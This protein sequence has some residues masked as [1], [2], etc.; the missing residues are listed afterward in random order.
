MD[1]SARGFVSVAVSSVASS[2]DAEAGACGLRADGSV[3]CWGDKYAGL[4]PEGE[5]SALSTGETPTCGVRVEGSIEC[6]GTDRG[7]SLRSWPGRFAAVGAAGTEVC[8]IHVGGRLECWDVNGEVW[9]EPNGEFGMVKAL[10]RREACGLRTDGTI[11]CTERLDFF[12]SPPE[13][14]FTTFDVARTTYDVWPTES[15]LYACGVRVGGEL[16][17]WGKRTGRPYAD[18]DAALWSPPAGQFVDVAT[19]PMYACAIGADGEVTCWGHEKRCFGY[20]DFDD[21]G[22]CGVWA[23][24]P[25]PA[26][27]FTQIDS[28]P[29]KDL[30]RIR[31][32]MCAVRR[33]GSVACWDDRDK[34][35]AT[36]PSGRFTSVD[37][38]SMCG[39]RVGGEA[40]CWGDLGERVMADGPIASIHGYARYGCGLRT[41]GEATCWGLQEYWGAASPPPAA[42]GP[43]TE[44]YVSGLRAC[45]LRPDG[46]AAC[47]GRNIGGVRDYGE[48]DPPPGPF[49]AL[50]LSNSLSCGLRPNG[51]IA[52]WGATNWVDQD[53][54]P[55]PFTAV[56]VVLDSV[57]CGLR[58]DGRAV[59]WGRDDYLPR[60]DPARYF[61]EPDE[62]DVTADVLWREYY[63]GGEFETISAY[64]RPPRAC[65][66]RPSGHVLCWS[67]NWPPAIDTTDQ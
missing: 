46:E 56:S 51:D 44:I 28:A 39:V 32:V 57:V 59:C 30:A 55:G 63:P 23:D 27:P 13:G 20:N 48:S 49:T 19:N 67:P 35:P 41:D 45:G 18:I 14:A 60:R 65:G 7:G 25:V 22:I 64:P 8:G 52:C 5:F 47:W 17:C 10:G 12:L 58:E 34:D 6:W 50:G 31:P 36:S 11:V 4:A 61:R 53:P 43:F 37:V 26:G 33:D 38:R 2:L 16:A 66:I 42:A 40:V 29:T 1:A 9:W 62:V 3:A 24:H 21:D 15:A 54:Q